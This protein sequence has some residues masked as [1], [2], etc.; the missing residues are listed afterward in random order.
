[1]F[2]CVLL[3]LIDYRGYISS[4]NIYFNNERQKQYTTSVM[5]K[6]EKS[7]KGGKNGRYKK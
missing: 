1:M 6:S 3:Q 2:M 4:L 7:K 5:K